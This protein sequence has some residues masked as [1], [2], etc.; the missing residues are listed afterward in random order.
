MLEW[1][2]QPAKSEWHDKRPVDRK[3]RTRPKHHQQCVSSDGKPY[4]LRMIALI[5]QMQDRM[6]RV[7]KMRISSFCSY[8][9]LWVA[10]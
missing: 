3:G 6:D 1:L 9:L 10:R 4:G 2:T 8:S 5:L 7:C